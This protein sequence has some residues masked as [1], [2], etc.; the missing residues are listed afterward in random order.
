VLLP[1]SP[2]Q[3][4]EKAAKEVEEVKR[5]LLELQE[6]KPRRVTTS[7]WNCRSSGSNV[8]APAAMAFLPPRLALRTPKET[9]RMT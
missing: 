7:R 2:A 1:A 4:Q 3:E 8:I 9:V 5:G 6:P